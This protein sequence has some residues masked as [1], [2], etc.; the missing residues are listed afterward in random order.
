M[1]ILGLH[2]SIYF[3]YIYIMMDI[4]KMRQTLNFLTCMQNAMCGE[5]TWNV[6]A[7]SRFVEA[8]FLW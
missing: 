1:V 2:T 7:A 4:G 5:K 6:V 3:L 8:I